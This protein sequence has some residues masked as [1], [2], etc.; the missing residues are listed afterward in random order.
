MRFLTALLLF[1]PIGLGACQTQTTRRAFRD[2]QAGAP[3]R[4][5]AQEAWEVV[6]GGRVVG[7]TVRFATSESPPRRFFSVRNE[8]QQELGFI[9]ADGRCYRYQAGEAQA[10][11]LGSGTVRDGVLLI[12]ELGPES[13]LSEVELEQ[14]AREARGD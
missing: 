3:L 5:E 8:F 7:V 10:R 4:A 14:L 9:D 1:L 11:W 13:E 2:V 12:L 6:A